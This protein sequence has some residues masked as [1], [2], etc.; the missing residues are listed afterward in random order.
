MTT[1]HA[2]KQDQNLLDGPHKDLRRARAAALN[3]VP[4]STGVAKAIGLVLPHLKGKLGGY[5]IR[6]PTPTG[7]ATDLTVQVRDEVSVAD[8]T[9]AYR[10]AAAQGPLKGYRDAGQCAA[11][12]GGGEGP[13]GEARQGPSR[14][15][16]DGT[17]LLLDVL[18]HDASAALRRRTRRS[19]TRTTGAARASSAGRGRGT[20]GAGGGTE[21][22]L[23]LL[24]SSG[25]ATLGGKLTSRCTWLASP[26]NSTSSALEVRADGP[27]DLFHP[28][29]VP[30]TEHA[31]PVLRHEHQVR[32]QR[33]TRSAYRCEGRSCRS[34][35]RHGTL[36]VCSSGTPTA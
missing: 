19:R 1:I 30:V 15:L 20:P 12:H 7:S 16:A 5:A 29:E 6:V 2:Y 17:V 25:R 11:V 23:R 24:T 36:L 18:P 22:P 4:T 34:I 32:V 3:M 27:H 9:E 35:N 31:M 14:A 10:A 28:R 33:G 13:R 21:T 8:I 26:L